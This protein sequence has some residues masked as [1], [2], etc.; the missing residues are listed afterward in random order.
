[1]KDQNKLKW[2]DVYHAKVTGGVLLRDGD[3]LYPDTQWG[4]E[5]GNGK[6]LLYQVKPH[7]S[8]WSFSKNL[9]TTYNSKLGRYATY[10]P[11]QW[12]RIHTE[13]D[14]SVFTQWLT[15]SLTNKRLDEEGYDMYDIVINKTSKGLERLVGTV[16]CTSYRY[17]GSYNTPDENLKTVTTHYIET[18]G[19]LVSELTDPWED[20]KHKAKFFNGE[21]PNLDLQHSFCLLEDGNI[22]FYPPFN[23]FA[24][25]RVREQL[26][27]QATFECMD[28]L[29]TVWDNGIQNMQGIFELANLLRDLK[30]GD[31]SGLST[32]VNDLWLQYRYVISTSVLDAQ[33]AVEATLRHALY[34]KI[35]AGG[36]ALISGQ[37]SYHDGDISIR[38]ICHMQV[39][40]LASNVA[41][42]LLQA[43]DRWGM[44]P[45]TYLVWDNIPYSFMVDWIIP[46]GD[47]LAVGDANSKF[48]QQFTIS[49]CMY[50]F[51]Y[52]R[53]IDGIQV[54]NYSR[55]VHQPFYPKGFTWLTDMYSTTGVKTIGKRLLDV[56]AIFGK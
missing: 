55:F 3:R 46:V 33:E 53:E 23:W 14:G 6:P 5:N 56:V 37:S 9:R 4:K 12:G 13:P 26:L 47:A 45:D 32:K 20:K 51:N 30:R 10:G 42:S 36:T 7:N 29:L 44:I 15:M 48:Q 1:M 24:A 54:K 8:E 39:K 2:N 17:T 41:D 19:L 50:S 52:T 22:P 21:V 28:S 40:S 27:E 49:N 25:E 35:N 38:C 11:C 31:F 43:L 18:L 34:E 16:I